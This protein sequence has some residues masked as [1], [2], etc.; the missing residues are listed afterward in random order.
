M[1]SYDAE[2]FNPPAPV[3]LVTLR[4]PGSSEMNLVVPSVDTGADIPLL[5]R[6][7]IEQLGAPLLADQQYELT[8]FDG[9][10]GVV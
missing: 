7:A 5:P 6:T 1:P 2:H 4:N 8:G 9:T 3:A 10:N